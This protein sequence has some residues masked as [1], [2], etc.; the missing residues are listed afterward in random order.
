MIA[1]QRMQLSR[2]KGFNLQ[3]ASIA[4]NGLAA[5]NIARPGP[6]GN[7]FIVGEDG[8]RPHCIALFCELLDGRYAIGARAPLA[9]QRA[10]V[11]HAADHWKTLKG[12]NLACWCAP[13]AEC[14]G[15]QLLARANVPTLCEA[16]S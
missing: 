11:V 3:A 12:K 7:P 16:L 10:F 13:G 5:I 8:A 4:L 9:A 15:D 2:A 6:W 1:P 14:H